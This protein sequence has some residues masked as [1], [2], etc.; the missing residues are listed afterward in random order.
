MKPEI[1]QEI[2]PDMKQEIKPDQKEG[3]SILNLV[4]SDHRNNRGLVIPNSKFLWDKN[5]PTGM[6]LR[7]LFF[8]RQMKWY[9]N[10][11]GVIVPH[12]GRGWDSNSRLLITDVPSATVSYMIENGGTIQSNGNTAVITYSDNGLSR[13]HVEKNI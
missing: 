6:A 9:G 2:K 5:D 1:K 10:K 7:G 11:F 4:H 13:I 3:G 8:P 12:S